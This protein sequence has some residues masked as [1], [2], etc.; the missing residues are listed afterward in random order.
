MNMQPETAREVSALGWRALGTIIAALVFLGAGVIYNTIVSYQSG[1]R[2]DQIERKQKRDHRA[3]QRLEPA[4]PVQSAAGTEPQPQSRGGDA[5]QS[6]KKGGQQPAPAPAGGGNQGGGQ[7]NGQAN[8]APDPSTSTPAAAA[9]P[10]AEEPIVELH[11]P[12]LGENSACVK[13]VVCAGR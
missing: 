7:G 4:K 11:V 2:F 1:H 9:A 10:K 13:G 8:T 12:A 5:I 3:I 6:P